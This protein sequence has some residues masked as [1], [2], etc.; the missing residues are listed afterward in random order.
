MPIR[1]LEIKIF[2]LPEGLRLQLG[3]RVA[4]GI[5]ATDPDLTV[6]RYP[7]LLTRRSVTPAKSPL[8]L[9]EETGLTLGQPCPPRP[10]RFVGP[11]L[12]VLLPRPAPQ[13]G[14]D[15]Q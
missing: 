6:S 2:P 14:V 10:E 3:G 15:A 8:P 9:D 7:A 5:A 4:G 11:Q 12:S 1:G 13:V